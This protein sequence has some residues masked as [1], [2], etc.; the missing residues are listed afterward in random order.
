MYGREILI[1]LAWLAVSATFGGAFIKHIKTDH[2]YMAGMD[3]G[4]LI[5]W[6]IRFVPIFPKF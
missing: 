3:L 6:F 2:P 4:F 5:Y 1:L